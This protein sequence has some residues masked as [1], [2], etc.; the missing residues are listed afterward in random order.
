[1]E[2]YKKFYGSNVREMPKLLAEGLS[3]ASVAYI[4][5]QRIKGENDFVKG[6]WGASDLLAYD[7][8]KKSDNVKFILA[9]DK[10]NQITEQG[11][12]AL[13]LIHY[14]NKSIFES[15]IKINDQYKEMIGDGIIEVARKDLGKIENRLTQSK[16]LN[17]K[18]WRILARH[19]DEVS[20]EFAED[21]NLLKEYIQWVQSKT[22]DTKNMGI[23]LD[24]QGENAKLRTWYLSDLEDRSYADA[25]TSFGSHYGRFAGISVGDASKEKNL[26][27]KIDKNILSA[28]NNGNAFE[29]NGV[30]YIPTKSE[31]LKLK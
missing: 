22:K 23:H 13:E 28:I 24:S 12:K 29:Y 19:P 5:K 18:A 15:S 6:Y 4:M 17:S 21:P 16:I 2:N 27:G 8:K 26:E 14:D 10:N 20:K 7:S 3:P 9:V 30:L 1:M 25:G 31:N 11:R